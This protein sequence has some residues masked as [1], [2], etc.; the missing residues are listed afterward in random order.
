MTTPTRNFDKEA[1][2]WD[3]NP[4]RIKLAEEVMRTITARIALTPEMEV[5]DFG[6]GTGLLALRLAPLVRSVTGMDRSQGML[7]VLAAK[8]AAQGL[9]NVRSQHLPPGDRP[10]GAYDLIVSSMTLH[11]VEHIDS[12]LARLFQ[13]CTSSGHLCVADLDPEQGQFH[14]DNTGVFHFG[15]DRPLLQE[16]LRTAGFVATGSETAAE[17]MK[18]TRD[19][20]LRRF[21]VF[22]IH[23][24][25]SGAGPGAA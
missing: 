9:T 18:P 23:G 8:A 5:L 3:E 14:H 11:H 6:C 20:D 7:D 2:F 12:L 4:A 19:G 13:A 16:R 15:F 1:A 10:S 24:A 17:V 22:L 21:T 25:K